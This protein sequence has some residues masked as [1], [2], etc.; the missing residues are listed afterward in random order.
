MRLRAGVVILIAC[1]FW[2]GDGV[3][4]VPITDS[5]LYYPQQNTSRDTAYRVLKVIDGDTIKIDFKGK[6]ET[7]R[8]IG[9]DTPE[10]VHPNKPVEPFGPEASSFLKNMLKGESVYLRF[11]EEKRG[12][13]GSLLAYIY[14]A[15]DAIFVNLEIVR[16]GYERSYRQFP[17]KH[18]EIFNNYE[19]IAREVGKG[20]WAGKS[21]K[22]S[23]KEV[24]ESVPQAD[25]DGNMT[26]YVTNS[27]KKYHL[28]SCRWGNVAISLAKAR[29]SYTPCAVCNPPK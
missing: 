4:H 5:G 29:D 3:S 9:V 26:V 8:L 1:L 15:P 27:G 20:L 25:V 17:R 12:K 6:S 16:Q 21:A 19:K 23:S 28:E 11:G 2:I 13:Y 10:T 7:V 14:R 18:L 22:P 24:S